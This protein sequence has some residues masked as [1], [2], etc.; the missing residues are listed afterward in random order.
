MSNKV[1]LALIEKPKNAD[2]LIQGRFTVWVELIPY[3][4]DWTSGIFL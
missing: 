3:D 1:I 2:S 4:R